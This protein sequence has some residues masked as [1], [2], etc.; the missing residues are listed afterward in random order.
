MELGEYEVDRKLLPPFRFTNDV[1]RELREAWMYEP[2]FKS[3]V[4]MKKTGKR[5]CKSI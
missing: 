2:S 4:G 5:T 1:G 3:E